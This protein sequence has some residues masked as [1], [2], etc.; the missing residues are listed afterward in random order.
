MTDQDPKYFHIVTTNLDD[1]EGGICCNIIQDAIEEFIFSDKYFPAGTWFTDT[2][3]VSPDG[4]FAYCRTHDDS[5]ERMFIRE[6]CYEEYRQLMDYW[7]VDA[8]EGD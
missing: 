6:V 5:A 1:F 8:P 2:I 4:S 7:G 3:Q